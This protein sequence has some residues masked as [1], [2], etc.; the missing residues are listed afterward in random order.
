MVLNA[1]AL[2]AMFAAS[3]KYK[4]PL[5]AIPRRRA[6]ALSCRGESA[7][8]AFRPALAWPRVY[9]YALTL[10]QYVFICAFIRS[11]DTFAALLGHWSVHRRGERALLL[12]QVRARRVR[13]G[14][15]D[16]RPQRA[17]HDDRDGAAVPVRAG[18]HGEALAGAGARARGH[19]SVRARDRVLAVARRISRS[20]AVALYI[21]YRL[22]HKRWI[23]ALTLVGV[24]AGLSLVPP[25]FYER[26]GTVQTAADNDAS[27]RGRINAWHASVAMAQDRPLTG[28]G[29]GNFLVHF[30]RYAPDPRDVHVAHSSFFQ[31]LGDAGLPG[32]A[33]WL[34]LVGALWFTASKVEKRIQ[35][36]DRACGPRLA[37]TR[38]PSKPRGSVRDLRGVPVARRLRFL[39]STAR[40]HFPTGGVHGCARTGGAQQRDPSR[41]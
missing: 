11:L 5:G 24:L 35:R 34:S 23:V 13:V 16:R 10:L 6:A 4:A 33:V 3:R 19:R 22:H 25:E 36:L 37:T 30:E 39:L 27:S 12:R 7:V 20:L 38:S 17:R 21:L 18:D 8:F 2:I 15:A 14:G 1:V 28:V 26:I 29:V 9:D 40:D 31:I 32:L 41:D